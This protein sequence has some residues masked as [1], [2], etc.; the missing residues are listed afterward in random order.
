MAI[1]RDDDVAFYKQVHRLLRAGQRGENRRNRDRKTYQCA[2]R[3]AP[4]V[5]GHTPP[6]SDFCEVKCQ[7]L[8]PG[9]FSFLASQPPEHETYV[10][11]LGKPPVLIYVTA[12]V[13]HVSE[14]RVGSQVQFLVGCRFTGRV[15]AE[16]GMA[17]GPSAAS[18]RT[19]S[20]RPTKRRREG[21]TRRR[22]DG[23]RQSDRPRRESRE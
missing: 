8:S 21:E 14:L 13:V 16:G 15:P 11:E 7:D 18:D 9:G 5:S 1:P 10:V 2:Q 3:L 12:R 6:L 22:G 20:S 23:R 4:L 19:S 17:P